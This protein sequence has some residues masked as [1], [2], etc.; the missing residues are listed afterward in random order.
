M[1]CQRAVA[2]IDAVVDGELDLITQLDFEAHLAD[3]A[4][5]QAAYAVRLALV[6]RVRAEGVRYAA[7]E[8]FR[9]RLLV[10]LPPD[11]VDHATVMSPVRSRR[12]WLMGGAWASSVAA[13]AASLVLTLGAPA[14][15]DQ[16]AHDLVA[17]HVRSLMPDHLTDVLSS[18]RHTVKP[19][20]N[21]RLA[22]SPPVPNPVEQGFPL[23]G[24]RLDYV[25]EHM[26]AALVYRRNQHLINLFVWAAPDRRDS[27]VRIEAHNGYN[28]L[29][30]WRAGVAYAMVSDLALT[31]LEG[32][33][34][35]WAA[36]AEEG[37][38][39]AAVAPTP[40]APR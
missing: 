33:Q 18:D 32:F 39:P 11:G 16:L 1:D 8:D 6:G 24:G 29:E 4:D 7:S 30:W 38:G 3:C 34:R 10:A 13:L 40:P 9:Q 17:A 23:V 15:Q 27:A 5:C 25:D 14:R 31:E 2:L 22:V 26:A 35:L 37:G 28:L 19:W 21:G 20:F 36:D 12:W